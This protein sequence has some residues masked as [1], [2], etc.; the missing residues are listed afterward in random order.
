MGV[1]SARSPTRKEGK[2][3]R[4]GVHLKIISELPLFPFV[5]NKWF[6][7]LSPK[8]FLLVLVVYGNILGLLISLSPRL[9]W[10]IEAEGNVGKRGR[11]R[12]TGRTFKSLTLACIRKFADNITD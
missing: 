9:V 2:K 11:V 5:L 10:V 7:F 3:E 4:E 8:L 12:A 1:L 6:C